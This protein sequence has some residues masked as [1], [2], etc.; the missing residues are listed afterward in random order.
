MPIRKSEQARYP[1]DWKAISA[2]IRFERAGGKCECTGQCGDTHE[3][4]ATILPPDEPSPPRCNAPHARHVLRHL[5]ESWRW[6][7][8]DEFEQ[9]EARGLDPAEWADRAIKVVLTVAHR[10]HY[11]PDC[12]D[13]NLLAMC[14]TCHLRMDAVL[15][16]E[17]GWRKRRERKATGDLFDDTGLAGHSSFC[18]RVTHPNSMHPCTCGPMDTDDANVV[19]QRDE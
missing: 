7:T 3:T 14:N 16:M 19:D 4:H 10:N 8:S 18:E 9:W 2:R 6:V 1:A 11:P 13:E 17:H 5:T 15:H 12:R